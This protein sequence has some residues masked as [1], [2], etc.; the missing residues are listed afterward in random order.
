MQPSIPSLH[1]FT[2]PFVVPQFTYR[3]SSLFFN[4]RIIHSWE[5][6]L[7]SAV[8]G[9]FQTKGIL[10]KIPRVPFFHNFSS[11]RDGIGQRWGLNHEPRARTKKACVRDFQVSHGRSRYDHLLTHHQRCNHEL[12]CPKST[13]DILTISCFHLVFRCAQSYKI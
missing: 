8:S 1:L 9:S 2:R 11:E 10:T 5:I 13:A 3:S 4:T 12:L 7:G 6:S